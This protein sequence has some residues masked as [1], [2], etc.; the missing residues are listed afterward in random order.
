M[1]GA[2]S[3]SPGTCGEATGWIPCGKQESRE[4]QEKEDSLVSF[5]QPSSD[6][7]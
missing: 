1:H 6:Q 7:V 2:V 4:D 5:A 3:L